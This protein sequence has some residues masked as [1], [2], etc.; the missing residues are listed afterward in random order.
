[1]AAYIC[2]TFETAF[3][4][5]F[6]IQELQPTYSASA[7]VVFV[8]CYVISPT[9]IVLGF[10]QELVLLPGC[11]EFNWLSITDTFILQ[12][13]TYWCIKVSV[14]ESFRVL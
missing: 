12:Y 1:M 4:R 13:D 6:G 11:E 8:L 7:Y 2:S 3:I 5:Q 14:I 10:M 9:V